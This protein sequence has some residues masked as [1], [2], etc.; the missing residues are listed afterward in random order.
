MVEVNVRMDQ[1]PPADMVYEGWLVDSDTKYKYSLGA[2]NG[3]ALNF[4]GHF[5]H[6]ESGVP[7]ETLAVSTEPIHD[8]N[9]MPM[10]VVAQG[11]LPGSRLSASDFPTQ[12]VL[13]E[14]E[15]FQRQVAMERFGLNDEQV[16]DLRMR[17][18]GYGQISVI[19]NAASRCNRPPSEV[20]RMLEQGQSWS[21]IAQACNIT[22]AQLLEPIPLAAV[23]GFR[24]ELRAGIPAPGMVAPPMFYQRMPNRMPVITQRNWEQMRKRGYSW[25]DVAIAANIAAQTGEDVEKL[26]R[27]TRIQGQ[28]WRQIAIRRGLN[29]EAMM[30]VS[31]WPFSRNGKEAVPVERPTVVPPPAPPTAPPPTY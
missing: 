25:K 13:P 12:A 10:T 22:V 21:E 30:D 9:P 15:T 2:F 3:Q 27:M 16:I 18:F 29:V 24:A 1:M 7:Y 8:A 17:A 23:A 11:N 5:V 14:D 20:A 31:G 19:A 6:F 26:L 4:R 28:T